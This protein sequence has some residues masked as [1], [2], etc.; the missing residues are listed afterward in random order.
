[1][2]PQTVDQPHARN[3]G[4]RRSRQQPQAEYV[5]HRGSIW[6]TAWSN[7]AS[8]RVR[9]GRDFATIRLHTVCAAREMEAR[10]ANA[11]NDG[12]CRCGL[13]DHTNQIR[14]SI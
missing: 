12:I 2:R 4:Q 5:A 10:D 8:G 14:G 13:F 6:S 7:W 3:L 11:P 1:M 9:A